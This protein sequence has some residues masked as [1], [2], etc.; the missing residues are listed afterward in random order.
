MSKQEK[1]SKS[2]DIGLKEDI[3][4]EKIIQFSG[5]IFLIAL[6]LFFGAWFFLDSIMDIIELEL[7]TS[8]FTI[9]IFLGIKGSKRLDF[10][11]LSET[12]ADDEIIKSLS[13]KSIDLERF[14][15]SKHIVFTDDYAPIE[16]MTAR[17]LDKN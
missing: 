7:G 17:L 6:I 2:K 16:K 9:I 5:W 12:F 4:F 8:T 15:L 13:E 10:D 14:D 3:K 1:K 11:K